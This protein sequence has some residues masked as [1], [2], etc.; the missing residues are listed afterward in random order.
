MAT[1]GMSQVLQTKQTH[2]GTAVANKFA[3]YDGLFRNE[4]GDL[5]AESADKRKVRVGRPHST[6]TGDH[7]QHGLTCALSCTTSLQEKYMTMVN[8]FYDL[9]TDFYEYGW[10]ESFHFACRWKGE[11]FRE[12]IM[13]SEHLVALKLQLKDGMRVAVHAQTVCRL[14]YPL[15]HLF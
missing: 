4:Q 9:V 12:S 13:R 2:G 1:P 14:C 15:L 3:T 8:S 6:V 7:D 5:S 10:G 11:T